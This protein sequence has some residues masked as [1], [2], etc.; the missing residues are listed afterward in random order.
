MY[1]AGPLS[2]PG[3]QPVYSVSPAHSSSYQH[4]AW[5]IGNPGLGEGEDKRWGRENGGE[6]SRERKREWTQKGRRVRDR[7]GKI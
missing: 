7:R 3:D 4:Q 2:P 6:K 5:N 1:L